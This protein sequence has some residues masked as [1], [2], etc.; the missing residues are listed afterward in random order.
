MKRRVYDIS[1]VTDKSLNVHYNGEKIKMKTFEKYMDLYLISGEKRV[2]QQIHERWELGLTLSKND[3]FEQ[4][5]FVNGIATP[6]GGKHVDYIAKIIIQKISNLIQKKN[7]DKKKI[8]ENYIKNYLRIFLNT[9]IENPS[10]DSQTKERL[11]TAPGKFGSKPEI[12]DKFIKSYVEKCGIIDKVLSFA[13]FKENKEA[14]KTDG[15]KKTK[16]NVPKLD[17]ANWAGTKKSE[18]CTL[19]LTEGDSAKSM[20]ISG[21][22]VIGRDKYGVFPLRGKVLN[23]KDASTKQMIDNSEITN[24][25]KILGLQVN[26]EYKDTKSLDMGKL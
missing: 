1:G 15:S 10:F 13:D 24:L 14:K 12:P 20:A 9:T 8:N 17:D 22:A 2:F 23:V 21:L 3:K 18:Q 26:K 7:K 25:K 19:I 11:I 6:K 5:S 4:I 16:I